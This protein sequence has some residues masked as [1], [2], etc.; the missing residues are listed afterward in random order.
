[1][2]KYRLLSTRAEKMAGIAMTR[3]VLTTIEANSGRCV[4][5]PRRALNHSIRPSIAKAIGVVARANR[6]AVRARTRSGSS[7]SSLLYFAHR[8]VTFIMP[9]PPVQKGGNLAQSQGLRR[10]APES[11]IPGEEGW[12]RIPRFL[13]SLGLLREIRQIQMT[14]RPAND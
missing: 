8:P 10:T 12:G 7:R 14:G 9:P 5:R 11:G 6:A 1:M 4:T 13:R 3:I 2:S